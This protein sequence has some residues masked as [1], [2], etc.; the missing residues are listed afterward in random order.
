MD[1]SADYSSGCD[2]QVDSDSNGTW[3]VTG[4]T[5]P[6]G[7]P[8]SNSSVVTLGTGS[9]GGQV[10]PVG[11]GSATVTFTYTAD[12]VT[13]SSSYSL[14]VQAGVP[15]SIWIAQAT[16]AAP[17]DS[18]CVPGG[19]G[20]ANLT[21]VPGQTGQFYVCANYGN[22]LVEDV[23]QNITWSQDSGLSQTG[24]VVSPEIVGTTLGE[25]L[26]GEPEGG[27]IAQASYSGTVTATLIAWGGAGGYPAPSPVVTTLPVT[28]N[29]ASPT[30]I[31]VTGGVGAD[32]DAQ[33]G[34]PLQL[35]ATATYDN[36][37]TVDVSNL[38]SWSSDSPDLAESD[39]DGAI[40]V[41][42]YENGGYA[43]ITAALGGISNTERIAVE[44]STP[45]TIT[46]TDADGGTVGLGQTDQLTA[47]AFIGGPL[48]QNLNP[49][50][51][52]SSDQP[53]I[54]TVSSTGVVTVVGG[55]QGQM[56]TIRATD[57]AYQ[58]TFV[59]TVDLTHPTSI[60][61]TPGTSTLGSGGSLTYTATGHYPGGYTANV[62]SFAT[63]T[64]NQP[65]SLVDFDLYQ[66][67]VAPNPTGSPIVITV[68]ASLG[69]A[70]P[71]TAT[72]TEGVGAPTNLTVSPVASGNPTQLSPGQ[73]VQLSA[74]AQFGTGSGATNDSVTNNV[75][76][77][78]SNT[79][80]VTVSQTGL[81]TAVGHTNNAVVDVYASYTD[82]FGTIGSNAADYV[83][84]LED[85][86]SITLGVPQATL[87]A[88]ESE[89]LTAT[90][91]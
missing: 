49:D 63:W 12:G 76:W 40:Q 41:P 44:S 22:G 13:K 80:V 28:I 62:S 42:Y 83:L 46:V 27:S 84:T 59:I 17:L 38:A 69:N 64:A 34:E 47:A 23:T 15:S 10:Q 4:S 79:S 16:S 9:D 89:Y 55:A 11:P 25:F 72:V 20:L 29:W 8:V 65:S 30:A 39:G 18:A 61:V 7:V 78:S 82:S 45:P 3:T 73:T 88:G 67:S 21:V 85:P 51:T 54:A 50:V 43:T 58:G 1:A 32:Q 26:V 75:T 71:A 52:W 56:V 6:N 2:Y 70:T 31:S 91:T 48:T 87:L 5:N 66:M 57:G 24:L 37:Q 35:S 14:T 53:N 68:T 74:S 19:S 90:G 86:S 77:V 81:V 33:G 36:G 60:A